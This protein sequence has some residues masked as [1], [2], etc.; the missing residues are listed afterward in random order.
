MKIFLLIVIVSISTLCHGQHFPFIHDANAGYYKILNKD[1]IDITKKFPNGRYKIFESDSSKIPQ[2]LFNIKENMVSGPFLELDG[3]K[4]TYGNYLNDSLWS[5]LKSPDDTTFKIGTWKTI[6]CFRGLSG[7]NDNCNSFQSLYKIPYDST[8]TYKEQWYYYNDSL[9]RE[10]IFQK[11]FGLKME[12]Y[13]DFETRKIIK[14]VI[15]TGNKNYYYTIIYKNDSI[16]SVSLKQDS[17]EIYI[18]YQPDLMQKSIEIQICCES[19]KGYELPVTFFTI[20]STKS[21]TRFNDDQKTIYMYEDQDGNV[22]LR[23]RNKNG[24]SK[25]KTLKIK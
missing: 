2:Y 1:L 12:T 25:F 15:N 19:K 5:F 8:N 6:Y 4:S 17:T 10:G 22:K 11:G 3:A 20:D 18:N 24:K 9:A 13:W 23:Y 16:A 21:M 14:Q 7:R